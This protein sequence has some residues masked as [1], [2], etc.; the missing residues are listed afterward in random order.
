MDDFHAEFGKIDQIANA[1]SACNELNIY[2][3]VQN[4]YVNG[5][6]RIEH[7]KHKLDQ[8]CDTSRVEWTET[9]C[10]PV[11]LGASLD[12]A[13]HQLIDI[14]DL[15]YGDCNAGEI[16]NIEADGSTKPCCGAGLMAGGLT[17]G[18]AKS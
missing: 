2:P 7:F 10:T 11:G 15:S 18:N 3:T 14:N 6:S 4:I 16:L 5:A 17:M 9:H 1:I 12:P 8:L 13:V